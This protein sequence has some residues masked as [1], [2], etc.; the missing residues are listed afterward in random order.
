MPSQAQQDAGNFK[1]EHRRVAGLDVSI[2]YPEGST[3]RGVASNGKPW[4]HQMTSSYGYIKRTVGADNEQV[5]VYVG[6]KHDSQKVF[7]VDQMD[8]QTGGFDEHKAMLGYDNQMQAM[9]AYR[10]NFDKGW[11]VGPVKAM[12]VDEFKGW[13]KNGDTKKPVNEAPAQTTS[14]P[15]AMNSVADSLPSK[16]AAASLGKE[17]SRDIGQFKQGMSEFRANQRRNELAKANP[18]VQYTV[19]EDD[20]LKNGFAVV[21][22]E[23]ATPVSRDKNG[24]PKVIY[25][26]EAATVVPKEN[27]LFGLVDKRGV[28]MEADP[29]K[30]HRFATEDEAIR[31]A[32]E[33]A[34]KDSPSTSVVGSPEQ[35]N[36]PAAKAATILAAALRTPMSSVESVQAAVRQLVNGIGVLPNSLGRIVVTTSD[37]IKSDWEPLIGKV[38]VKSESK[39][40]AL[41]FYSPKTKTVFLIADNIPAGQEMG[42]AAH[43]LMHKHGETVLGKEGWDK[44][45]GAIEGWATAKPGSLEREVY[46]EAAQ[47][48]R[49][50]GAD[51]SNQEL[52]P[53]AVQVALEYGVRPNAMAP[54]G[55]V[56]RWL[57]AV[58]KA[59]R[60]AWDKIT[61]KPDLFKTQDLVDLAFGIA[62]MENPEHAPAVAEAMAP[63]PERLKALATLARAGSNEN[64]TVDMGKVSPGQAAVLSREGLP[65]TPGFT[66]TADVY[67][68][69]H[70]FKKHGDEAAERARGQVPITD[71]EI[72]RIPE[73]LAAPDAYILGAKSKI[74]RDLVGYVKVQDDGTALYI[75][76]VRTGKNRL[77]MTSIRKYPA[78]KNATEAIRSVLLNVRNDGGDVRIIYP[79]AKPG[80]E[81]APAEGAKP[82]DSSGDQ[83]YSRSKIIGETKRVYSPELLRAME[84]VGFKV[85]VPTM[86][87]R[88]QAIWKDA[89]KKLAQGIVDQFAPIKDLDKEAYGL[90]RLA[91]GAAG[92]FETLLKGG[93]L[94]LS[95][96][97]YD[98]DEA[99]KGGVVDA[100]LTP[101]NGEH[102]DFLRWVAANR[103]ERLMGE[104]HERLFT[105]DDIAALKTLADRQL[106]FD[107]TLKNGPRK[108]ET[109]RSRAEAYKDSLTTFNAFNKNVLDM[110]E[111]SGLIDGGSR[112]L[113]E[114]EFYVPF[115]R[116][117]EDG[118]A[119]GTNIKGS[120]VRQEAFK[121]LKGGKNALNA[122]LMDNTLMNWA[123][124]LDAAAK[125]RAAKATIEAAERMGVAMPGTESTLGQMASSI[126][127]KKGVVW[128]MDG[129]QKRYSLISDQDAGPRILTAISSLEYAGMKNPVMNA[130]SAFKHALT[131]GVTASPFFK[132]RNLIRDSVQAIG[133]S[134]LGYN[135]AANLAQGW[136]LTDPKS[137]AYFR[138]LAGGGTIHFGT[139]LEGSQGKRIQQLVESGVDAAT[140]L[141]DQNAVNAFY[142]RYVQPAVHA[143]NELGD[144]G[145]AINRAA[146]YDQLVK[147]GVSH[148]EA[149]LQARDLMDFSMQGSFATVRF[150]TQVVPFMNARIQGLYKLGKSAKEDP[151]KF[152]TVLGAVAAVSVGLLAAYADDDDWKKREDWDRNN[153]WWFKVGGTAIRIPKPFEMGAIG[154]LAER[155]FELAFDKEM[156]N[157]RFLDQVMTL[158]GDNLS[159]NP[160]PQLVKPMLDV[161]ANKD[162]F[163]GRP[164][165]SLGMEKLKSEY[166]FNGN[167]SMTARALS[168]GMNAVTGLVGQDSLSP[169]QIDSMLRGY[170]GWLGSFVVGAA[171]VLARPATDQPEKA[172]PDYWKDA[173]GGIV[174]DLRNAPSR[175]VSAMYA[176]AKELEQAYGTWKS[177]V[178]EGKVEEAQAFRQDHQDELSRYRQVEQ[179]KKAE[180]SLNARQ[181]M[182][183]RSN[184][185]PDT[186]RELIRKLQEQKDQR[187]RVLNPA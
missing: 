187:A 27:G 58:T 57:A 133:V 124:L 64:L 32:A 15:V 138:L 50:S 46:E 52:F 166:R 150:L 85:E 127:N 184:V 23:L 149:S 156:T 8:Q 36:A 115:Y 26:G 118:G 2:E 100:L 69:R 56:A 185:D 172:T 7:V 75:E 165:E 95:G 180:A 17:V 179:V 134:E 162:S 182:I 143:Y 60:E 81:S 104:D 25:R 119:G 96:G 16:A 41:G 161:Y 4:S 5:D 39:G 147:R 9:R 120:Y 10:S 45:H 88:A 94:K 78:A 33:H 34:S 144:R 35:K 164:I 92:A 28:R 62:Q 105:P 110:A 167:T 113:W 48:V 63:T 43:E 31:Y 76:E 176:Q 114:H 136:K 139:M 175:Y 83:Q 29:Q 163:S 151:A 93:K 101:L 99:N 84:H 79:D 55:T 67:A 108:G 146:L 153:F 42:V 24:Y 158:A 11:K 109:T 122:D 135:P 19:E 130:M 169:V 152:A 126:G 70:A 186:K 44:L 102:H 6:P 121:A 90:M 181:R 22:R 112:H 123:H 12:S 49:D 72:A 141:K 47:R 98:F 21:G 174:S 157:K 61:G 142:K 117:S 20:K 132:V 171:D 40:D 38:D 86:K 154:T 107:F 77:A 89:G 168:T 82:G 71:A 37:K 140:I 51:L 129:G 111:Q 106:S 183:E 73:I 160:I 1:K 80:Q 131:L 178:K 74:G 125:N 173:T 159:M 3:R 148:A 145:E 53:Y 66:H 87:E 97:V 155:G 68:V 18:G 13:L 91:K 14:A 170:F 65:V 116:V 59:M 128:F 54:Q 177:L 30:R 137:D 103:A